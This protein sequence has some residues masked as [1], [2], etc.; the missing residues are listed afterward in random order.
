MDQNAVLNEEFKKQLSSQLVTMQMQLQKPQVKSIT[1]NESF[2]DA[3]INVASRSIES[4]RDSIED[5]VPELANSFKSKGLP[6]FVKDRT[7]EKPPVVKSTKEE[8]VITDKQEQ[9]DPRDQI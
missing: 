4:L 6:V 7:E 3:V 5:L 8:S 1:D 9:I 2:S